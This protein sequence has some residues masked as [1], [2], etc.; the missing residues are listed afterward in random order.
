MEFNIIFKNLK[1]RMSDGANDVA[2]FRELM[3]MITSVEEYDWNTNKDPATRLTK[4]ETLRTYSKRGLTS[5][6]ARSIV[7]YLT[8]ENLVERINERP[9]VLREMLVSDF[10]A[11]DDELNSSNVGEK[12][13][14]WLV[15]DIKKTAGLVSKTE[16]EQSRPEEL[17]IEFK[18]KF[19]TYLVD[20]AQ[21][22]CPFLGCGNSLVITAD[23]SANVAYCYEVNLIDKEGPRSLDNMIA[24][25]PRCHSAYVLDSDKKKSK[26]LREIKRILMSHKQSLTLLDTMSLEKG[27]TSV[28]KRL[29]KLNESDLENASLDAKELTTKID[30]KKNR[31]L[32]EEVKWQVTT[33]FKNLKEIMI[34]LD[35]RK[36]IDYENI[37]NQI[38]TMYKRLKEAKKSDI[39]IFDELS[40]KIHRMTLQPEKY[41]NIVVSFFI[42]KCEVF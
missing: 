29:V 32:Y 40:G 42:Q 24:S 20:D 1:T 12:V 31:V 2:F 3:E 25:C 33:Y 30:P 4:V 23:G 6:L 17:E 7:Y 22:F 18:R 34:S 16:L 13:A 35:K 5:K 10:K 15:E 9:P 38:H 19:G 36:E 8:P 37:Q 28:M 39:E 26:E 14:E 11:Y 21:K 41:C 27:I